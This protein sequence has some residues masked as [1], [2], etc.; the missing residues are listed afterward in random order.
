MGKAPRPS[1]LTVWV[2][3][4]CPTPL[5]LLLISTL[6]RHRL[7]LVIP[8]EAERMRAQ[9]RDLLF[10]CATTN[11]AAPPL[12]PL[13]G[14]EFTNRTAKDLDRATE[15]L[16]IPISRAETGKGTTSSRATPH[17]KKD[18]ALAPEV[19]SS[20]RFGVAR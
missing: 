9:W 3:H 13:Q 10:P 7:R 17:L 1:L 5:N 4:S 18:R 14:W 19:P 16:E 2:G 8:T 20:V 6:R 15:K 11:E 12:R